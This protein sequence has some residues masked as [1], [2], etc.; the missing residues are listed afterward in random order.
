MG[1][2][3]SKNLIYTV[4]VPESDEIGYSMI[5][6]NPDRATTDNLTQVLGCSSFYLLFQ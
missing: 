6:Q 2:N 5:L 1:K 3:H 4:A